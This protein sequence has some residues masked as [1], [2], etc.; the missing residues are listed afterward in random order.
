MSQDGQ[1]VAAAGRFNSDEIDTDTGQNFLEIDTSQQIL[2]D[3][4]YRRK[5]CH[6]SPPSKLM[7][8]DINASRN[9]VDPQLSFTDTTRRY[10][11]HRAGVHKTKTDP[12]Q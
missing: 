12:Q 4:A 7:R 2:E 1:P 3:N 9:P 8:T 5:N 10:A 6:T 11:E